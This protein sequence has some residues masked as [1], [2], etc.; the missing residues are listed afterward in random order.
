[1]YALAACIN[2]D[3]D[4]PAVQ[5]KGSLGRVIGSCDMMVTPFYDPQW[6]ARSSEI[7]QAHTSGGPDEVEQDDDE[8]SFYDAPAFTDYLS[9]GWCR[10]EMFFNANIPMNPLRWK[11]FGGNL[12]RV[13]EQEKRRPHLVYGTREKDNG[14]MPVI[15]PALRDHL[16]TKYHPGRGDLC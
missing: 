4:N 9:R 3:C 10:I 2:Q 6:Q 13:M 15:L 1:M 16:F 5:L 12:G 11:L 14:S 8:F 7:P